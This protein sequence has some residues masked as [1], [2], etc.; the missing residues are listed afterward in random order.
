MKFKTEYFYDNKS[1]KKEDI[2]EYKIH[3]SIMI[4]DV[5]YFV[6]KCYIDLIKNVQIIQLER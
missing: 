4:N 3:D 2:S 1:M 6:K 5:K